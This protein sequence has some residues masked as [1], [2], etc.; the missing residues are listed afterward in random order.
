MQ[1][2]KLI[3][4]LP[5]I[6]IRLDQDGFLERYLQGFDIEIDRLLAITKQ[7]LNSKDASK[8]ENKYLALLGSNVG[9]RWNGNRSYDW[10]RQKIETAITRASYKSTTL[11]I[12]DLLV[13]H[14]A[15]R[16]QITDMASLVEIWNT[17]SGMFF[18]ADFFHPG[19][20]QLSISEDVDLLSFFEDFE[21]LKAAGTRWY[22]RIFPVDTK[23]SI[24]LSAYGYPILKVGPGNTINPNQT[25]W[26]N[27]KPQPP[28]FGLGGG[29][30]I[31]AGTITAP[32]AEVVDSGAVAPEYV[33]YYDGGRIYKV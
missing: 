8:I 21:Y 1:R 2:K 25:W 10:N 16:H 6:W 27:Y 14:G 23:A 31:D 13:E 12:S 5:D 15:S 20:Y 26:W 30:Y 17:Q 7:I 33:D 22:F 29:G 9:H 32:Y 19:V 11:S 4:R 24:G 18:D 28:A 3:D